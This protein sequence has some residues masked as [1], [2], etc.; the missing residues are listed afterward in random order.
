MNTQQSLSLGV[1]KNFILKKAQ[2]TF[3]GEEKVILEQC[4]NLGNWCVILL[5][6]LVFVFFLLSCA[7]V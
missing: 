5:K 2:I 1:H 4:L 6:S 3:L 7:S